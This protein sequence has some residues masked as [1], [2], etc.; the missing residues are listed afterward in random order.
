[1]TPL[2]AVVNTVLAIL[3]WL[4]VTRLLV[5]NWSRGGAI[6]TLVLAFLILNFAY[7][8][9][10]AVVAVGLMLLFVPNLARSGLGSTLMRWLLALTDPV[11]D[12]VRRVFG[13]RLSTGPAVLIAALLVLGARVSLFLAL[14]R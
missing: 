7:D 11:V 14:G 1:M 13:E 12:L 4:L 5:T 10:I 9:I 3:L 8:L 2:F 6:V